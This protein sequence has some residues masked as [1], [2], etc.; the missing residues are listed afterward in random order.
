MRNDKP[1]VLS[2]KLDIYIIDRQHMEQIL[3][4]LILIN[5][6]TFSNNIY[7]DR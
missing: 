4:Y 3:I 5:Q 2:M 6:I 7:L 1:L